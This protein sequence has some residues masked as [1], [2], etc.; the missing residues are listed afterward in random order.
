MIFL[1]AI[2]L[3]TSA[4]TTYEIVENKSFFEEHKQEVKKVYIYPNKEKQ[5]NNK[6]NECTK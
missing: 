2:F 4:V 1:V 3:V 5:L 6:K